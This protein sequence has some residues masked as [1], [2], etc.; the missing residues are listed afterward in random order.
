MKRFS[1]FLILSLFAVNALAQNQV[2]LRQQNFPMAVTTE[3]D[4]IEWQRD[5]YREINLTEE[6]NEGLYCPV[7][8]TPNQKGLFTMLFKLAVNRLVPIY[9]YNIDG[10]EVFNDVTKADIKDVLINHHIFYQEEDGQIIVDQNDVPAQ[11]VT[12]YYLKEGVYYD[13]TNSSFRRKVLAICPVLIEEDGIDSEKTKYPLFWM[14][15]KDI[16][17]FIKDLTIIPSYRNKSMV[18][19]MTDYFTLNKYKGSIYKVAN[20]FGLTLRQTVESDS[21]MVVEQQRI[22]RELKE[23]QKTTYNTY[24]NSETKSNSK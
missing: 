4:N 22:E 19:P 5:V 1:N 20:A 18:M 24:Y 14:E 21:A 2:T 6:E 13:L 8:P 17:P 10:N 16:E 9:K 12:L 23:I 3:E 7:E 11:E 15:Y